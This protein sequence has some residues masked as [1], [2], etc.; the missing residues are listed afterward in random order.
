MEGMFDYTRSTTAVLIYF[1]GRST[2][3]QGP[4]VCIAGAEPEK[5]RGQFEWP[6]FAASSAAGALSPCLENKSDEASD[7]AVCSRRR[8]TESCS[9]GSRQRGPP[10]ALFAKDTDSLGQCNN[11]LSQVPRNIPAKSTIMVTEPDARS[12]ASIG[13]EAR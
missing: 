12:H 13:R 6:R 1:S 2:P 7:G 3:K 8:S 11:I 10:F 9:E 4:A 5:K